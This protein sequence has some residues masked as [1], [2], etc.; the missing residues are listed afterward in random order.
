MQISQ[1]IFLS[2]SIRFKILKADDMMDLTDLDKK[3]ASVSYINSAAT[4]KFEIFRNKK[5]EF[6]IYNK[7]QG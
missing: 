6:T 7:S 3:G 2:K 5:L 4:K 1:V